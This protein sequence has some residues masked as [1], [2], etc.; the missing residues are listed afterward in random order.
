MNHSKERKVLIYLFGSLGDTIVAVP[1]L[2]AIRRHFHGSQLVLLQ[3]IQNGNLVKASE[4]LPEGLVDRHLAYKN[5]LAGS[6]KI[7]EFYLLWRRL[8]REHFDAVVYLVN[9]ERPARSV[10]RD[11]FFFD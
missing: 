8:R 5:E 3:N 9:S 7:S 6:E 4:T 1:A 11:R 10:F 2:R